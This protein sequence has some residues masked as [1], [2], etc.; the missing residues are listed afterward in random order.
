[1]SRRQR[2]CDGIA[3]RL[4]ATIDNIIIT[5]HERIAALAN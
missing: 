2:L 1:M 3:A 5:Q 4:C